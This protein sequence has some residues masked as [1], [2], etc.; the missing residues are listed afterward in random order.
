MNL[1]PFW[2]AVHVGIGVTGTR[3]GRAVMRYLIEDVPGRLCG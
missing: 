1:S 3:A 2:Y